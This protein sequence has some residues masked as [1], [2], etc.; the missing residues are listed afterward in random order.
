MNSSE[1]TW[2]WDESTYS[3]SG[4]FSVLVADTEE[5]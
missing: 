2:G 1:T 3:Y 4:H 5:L